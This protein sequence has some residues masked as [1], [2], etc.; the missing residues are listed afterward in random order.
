M[1]G[2]NLFKK[3]L[4]ITGLLLQFN[5]WAQI[6]PI[7]LHV[8]TAGTLPTMMGATRK[9][10]ITDLTL[11]GKLNG[12]DI[13]F[14]REMAGR[15]ADGDA[16]SGKLAI[17]N[18]AGADIV[19]GGDYYYYYDYNHDKY[20]TSNNAISGRMFHECS[21]TSV[22][23]PNSVTLIEESAFSGCTGLTS[24]TIPN[25]VT[26]IGDWAF[27]GCSRLTSVTIGNSVTSIGERAFYG[28][29][30]LTEIHSKNPT[31]P[32]LGSSCFYDANI[33]TCKLYVPKGS[34]MAY[35]LAWGFD[36]II[37]EDGTAIT[38]IGKR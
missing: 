23:I 25:S 6:P 37:E 34:Y 2:T 8:E 31:P 7:T 32:K 24:V 38:Q 19:S 20:Y 29:S 33:T 5:V 18:L 11:T 4:V 17:L 36:N 27:Y 14:I 21:I 26:S 12:T 15:D 1:K 10:Q 13:L 28:C 22:M 30:G 9:Y 35:W 3:L 16:T